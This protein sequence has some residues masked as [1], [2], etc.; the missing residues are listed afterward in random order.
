MAKG[1]GTTLREMADGGTNLSA[2]GNRTELTKSAFRYPAVA[3]PLPECGT[4]RPEIF[5]SILI[6]VVRSLTNP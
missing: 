4:H 3:Y 5:R 1:M 6:R 2:S